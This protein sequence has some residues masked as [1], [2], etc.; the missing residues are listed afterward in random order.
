MTRTKPALFVVP[1]IAFECLFA[2][3]MAMV[4]LRAALRCVGGRLLMRLLSDELSRYEGPEP[5][6]EARPALLN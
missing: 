4:L 1:T 6:R 2:Y 3:L 5:Q